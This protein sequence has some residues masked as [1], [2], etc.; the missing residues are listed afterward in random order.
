GFRFRIGQML[1]F[2][3][4]RGHT[5]TVEVLPKGPLR[6]W[7]FFRRL[8]AYDAVVVQQR[9]FSGIDLA[10]LRRNSRRLIYDLDDAVMLGANPRYERRCMARFRS[11]AGAAD[12]LICGNA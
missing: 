10:C 2:F 6:R 1:P 12:L 9:L 7:R 3:A 4:Q 8:A 5:F 11:M